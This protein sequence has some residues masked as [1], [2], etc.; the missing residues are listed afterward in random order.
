MGVAM[1]VPDMIWY[2]LRLRAP[3]SMLSQLGFQ[4][5]AG[6]GGAG[7]AGGG[8]TDWER[9]D[10][11][12]VPG[13]TMSGLTRLVLASVL[14]RTLP[15]SLNSAMSPALSDM[16]YAPAGVPALALKAAWL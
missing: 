9:R 12:L 11:T 10:S 6:I 7:A 3:G 13:A 2:R 15:R 5:A 8:G 4:K 14:V 16:P 1:L